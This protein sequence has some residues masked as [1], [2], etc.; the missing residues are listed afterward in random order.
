MIQHVIK[1][2]TDRH[3]AYTDLLTR[4]RAMLWHLCWERANGDYDRCQ[5]LLQEVSIQLWENFGKLRPD[6]GTRQERAWV[7]WQ[8]RSVF[9]QM[10]R[11]RTLPTVPITDENTNTLADE[12]SKHRKELI[13]GLISSLTP[14]EQRMMRLF[15]EGYRGDEIGAAMGLNRDAVY[16]R[17]RRT[18]QKMR[19]VALILLALLVTTVVAVAVVPEWRQHFFGKGGDEENLIDTIPTQTEPTP[20]KRDTIPSTNKVRRT[21]KAKPEPLEKLPPL[22]IIS[23][24]DSGDETVQPPDDDEPTVSLDGTRLTITG[25]DGELIRLFDCTGNLVAAQKA[26][27]ICTIDLFPSTS[28]FKGLAS[29]GSAIATGSCNDYILQIGDR[30]AMKIQLR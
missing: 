13:D 11:K 26:T 20:Q 23:F 4:H 25:V 7:R 10:G 9:Y 16:Q 3:S 18:I 30:P 14:D 21:P 29:N 27:V 6:A 12:E 22:D 8:A 1:L 28:A 17:M 2:M 5:D 24:M 19:R 15:L